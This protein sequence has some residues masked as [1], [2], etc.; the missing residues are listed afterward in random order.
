LEGIVGSL[1]GSVVF[2]DRL[3]GRDADVK[4]LG[5]RLAESLIEKGAAK[6]LD[7]ARAST[8]GPASA[9]EAVV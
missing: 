5:I 9:A 1:D 3:V 8:D 4:A 7:D 2:R 6:L